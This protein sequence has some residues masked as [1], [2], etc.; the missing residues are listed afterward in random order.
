MKRAA[1]ARRRNIEDVLGAVVI[2]VI[3]TIIGFG[4]MWIGSGK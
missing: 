3:A 1:A 2:A 4:L